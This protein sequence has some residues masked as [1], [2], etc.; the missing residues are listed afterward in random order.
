[1]DAGEVILAIVA[2]KLIL[3]RQMNG[4]PFGELSDLQ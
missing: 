3:R 1:M 2:T 4:S